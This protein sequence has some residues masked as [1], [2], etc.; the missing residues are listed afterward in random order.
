MQ[1][2]SN[3]E[4]TD[5]TGTDWIIVS[6]TCIAGTHKNIGLF[7]INSGVSVSVYPSTL[8]FAPWDGARYGQV[9]IY[10]STIIID[11]L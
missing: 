6:D 7:K 5:H 9:Q 4:D 1:P 11:G 8:T 2:L 3:L 10:A